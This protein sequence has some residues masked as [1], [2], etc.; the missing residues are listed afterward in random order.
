MNQLPLFAPSALQESGPADCCLLLEST[1]EQ[2]ISVSRLRGRIV[3]HC[4]GKAS[5]KERE[6]IG[7]SVP[8]FQADTNLLLDHTPPFCS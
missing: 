6:E 1:V 3:F 8:L 5:E 7:M 4:C 2:R